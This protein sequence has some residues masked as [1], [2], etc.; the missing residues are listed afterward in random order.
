MGGGR[1]PKICELATI[2]SLGFIEACQKV[3][4]HK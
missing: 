2:C 3:P 4:Q 1:R